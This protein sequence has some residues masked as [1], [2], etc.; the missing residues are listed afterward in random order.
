MSATILIRIFLR[1]RYN[2]LRNSP[3]WVN[4]TAYSNRPAL[5]P[6]RSAQVCFLA[7]CL[8]R[9]HDMYGRL[10]NRVPQSVTLNHKCPAPQCQADLKRCLHF[11]SFGLALF[12]S[13]ILIK[14]QKAE[15]N[16]S[17]KNHGQRMTKPLRYLTV[18]RGLVPDLGIYDVEG[19][20]TQILQNC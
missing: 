12:L 20:P 9:R 5:L 15:A 10:R 1:L 17:K 18:D 4:S 2:S 3:S 7:R 11:L 16:S 13:V 6:T 19:V 14:I 8:Q